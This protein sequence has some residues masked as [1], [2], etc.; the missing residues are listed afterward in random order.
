M[1]VEI[2]ERFVEQENVWLKDQRPGQG[3]PLLLASGKG[4]RLTI[5]FAR[6][7]PDLLQYRV[8]PTC[9]VG[10]RDPANF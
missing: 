4:G 6:T 5:P 2:G 8:N 10:F 9:T 3:D 1:P 7:Q